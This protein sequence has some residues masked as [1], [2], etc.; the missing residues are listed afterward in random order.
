VMWWSLLA[1]FVGVVCGRSVWFMRRM[2]SLNVA[3]ARANA[4]AAAQATA[5][6]VVIIGDGLG[7]VDGGSVAAVSGVLG[8][9]GPR[10]ALVHGREV[11]DVD[12]S[13][14]DERVTA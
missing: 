3:E 7:A 2:R 8:A 12:W 14:A 6:G 13:E 11:I 5:T 9:S 10:G 4:R 1:F